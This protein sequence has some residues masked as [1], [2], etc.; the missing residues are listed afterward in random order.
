MIRNAFAALVDPW[1]FLRRYDESL[2]AH[3]ES[4]TRQLIG[5]LVE[6]E[7]TAFGIYD[8]WMELLR[9]DWGPDGEQALIASFRRPLKSA[10][11]YSDRLS[12]RLQARADGIVSEISGS[13]R[14]KTVLDWGCG[15]ARVADGIARTCRGLTLLD[16]EDVR[17]RQ[18]E[19]PFILYDEDAGVGRIDGSIDTVL[20]LTV[21]HHSQRPGRTLHDAASVGAETITVIESVPLIPV[22]DELLETHPGQAHQLRMDYCGYIDWLYNRVLCEDVQ[23]TYNYLHPAAWTQMFLAAGYDLMDSKDLGVDID[24]VPEWHVLL[25][26]RRRED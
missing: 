5:A 2:L 23:V 20:L 22:P 4:S 16:I 24:I 26:Y 17:S 14:N 18:L 1:G 11:G 12:D 21:L 9:Q 19:T 10:A 8:E 3:F 7:T 25:R 6:D 15:D 13:I